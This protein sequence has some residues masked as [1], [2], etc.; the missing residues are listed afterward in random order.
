M[1]EA[2][3]SSSRGYKDSEGVF[4][5]G[6][7]SVRGLTLLQSARESFSGATKSPLREHHYAYDFNNLSVLAYS[8]QSRNIVSKLAS[9]KSREALNVAYVEYHL[10]FIRILFTSF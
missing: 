6:V 4:C 9:S 5:W 10:T 3:F 2:I 8:Q 7:C 1:Y